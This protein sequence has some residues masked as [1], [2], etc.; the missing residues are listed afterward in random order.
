MMAHLVNW[1]PVKIGRSAVK[2]SDTDFSECSDVDMNV[3]L[4]LTIQEKEYQ[5][6][7]LL[8]LGKMHSGHIGCAIV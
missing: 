6:L 3:S 7:S 4:Y 1:S 8:R 2:V 5:V